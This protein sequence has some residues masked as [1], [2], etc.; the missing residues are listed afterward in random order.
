MPNLCTAG[1]VPKPPFR[2]SPVT[3]AHSA[4]PGDDGDVPDP[5]VL[6]D[7][8]LASEALG[9]G[10]VARRLGVA[11]PTLRSWG[12]RYGLEPSGR[13]S[14]GH[15]RYTAA[16]VARL[17]VMLRL[18]RQGVPTATAAK[19]VRGTTVIPELT[20]RTDVR[21]AYQ[22]VAAQI[23][24]AGDRQRLLRTLAD[25]M[26]VLGL[27]TAIETAL[28]TDGALPV[29]TDLVVPLLG[30]LRDRTTGAVGGAEV[31]RQTAEVVA[32]CLH[33][34]AGQ[35][36]ARRPPDPAARPVLLA[37]LPGESHPLPLL[38]IA[39][40]LAERGVLGQVLGAGVPP[41][42]LS[43]AVTR[44]RPTAVVV[45]AGLEP[46]ASPRALAALTR[47]RPAHP[48]IAAGPGWTGTTTPRARQ[49][50]TAAEAVTLLTHR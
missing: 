49:A 44:C 22:G 8:A 17:Q 43:A 46:A 34:Y 32:G 11:A 26:D 10:A 20:L 39:A 28:G 18:V 37:T 35:V 24:D 7:P 2:D 3:G 33:R 27:Q 1:P 13:S 30:G 42:V 19:A 50:R 21:P 14:G 9:V 45:W 29:W 15:R 31:E 41:E 48:V 5:D 40:A 23:R 12:R 16:D 25:R 47:S 36:W 38:A 4:S 6:R